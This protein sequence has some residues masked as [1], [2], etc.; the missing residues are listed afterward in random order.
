MK[1]FSVCLFG[2]LLVFVM[3]V[4]AQVYLSVDF[5]AAQG[6]ADGP[7][8]GQP[9]KSA[10]Q[11]TDF[12]PDTP[13]TTYVVDNGALL[14][15]EETVDAHWAVMDIPVMKE[16][17][18]AAWDMQFI[19]ESAGIIDVGICFSDKANYELD[20]NSVPTYNEQGTMVRTN[21]QGFI[22]A[23]NGDLEGGGEYPATTFNYQDG[24][25]IHVRIEVDAKNLTYDVFLKKEGDATETQIADDYFF[26]RMP[27]DQT[28]G[29]NCLAIW[30]QGA[31]AVVGSQCRLDNFIVYGKADVAAWSIF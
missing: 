9:A 28:G 29:L 6:Y 15:K 13:A 17:F 31:A 20:G 24:K 16:T 11:W 1:K 10:V 18:T 27:S 23:R 4:Q 12:N 5:S 14:I 7:V 2:M 8:I 30:Q 26:R 25:K 19:G 21:P 22:D 3:G